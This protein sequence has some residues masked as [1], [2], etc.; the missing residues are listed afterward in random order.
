MTRSF[1]IAV[2]LMLSGMLAA[3]GDPLVDALRRYQD[4]D[5][6]EARRLIDQAVKDPALAKDA[7]AWLLRGFVY[8]DAFKE[9]TPGAAADELRDEGLGSLITCLELDKENTFRD[10]ATQAYD[11]LARTFFNDAAKALNDLDDV[12]ATD[13]YARFKQA[14][15]RMDPKADLRA[16]DI[17]FHNALGT[18]HTKRFNQERSKVDRF[19]KAVAAYEA[20]LRMDPENYGAN[21]NLATLYYNRGVYNIQR[22]TS[23]D[24]IP[25][26]QQMQDVSK[27]FFMKALPYM[28][29]AHQMDPSRRETLL[30]LEGIYY[31]LQDPD[32]SDKYRKL[33]EELAP[34]EKDR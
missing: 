17:E 18:V 32:R 31:S 12:R 16:R 7:Q 15:Q 6:A 1:L 20:V 3:Q 25:T 22:I 28:L 30:G 33:Y 5:L 13:M 24:D 23:E 26:I 2:M 4:G 19:D 27:E 8:K 10:N 9:A 34:L 21:Y 11:F 14:V 29:K